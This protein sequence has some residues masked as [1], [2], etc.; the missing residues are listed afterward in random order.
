[1]SAVNQF[2]TTTSLKRIPTKYLKIILNPIKVD[3]STIGLWEDDE[4]KIFNCNSLAKWIRDN[5]SNI[6]EDILDA[7]YYINSLIKGRMHDRI[8]GE[9]SQIGHAELGDEGMLASKI[10]APEIKPSF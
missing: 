7:F 9:L 10:Y 3:L 6:P 5:T 4:Q 2:L 1:M 8:F